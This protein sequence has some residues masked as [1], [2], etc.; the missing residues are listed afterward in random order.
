M[1]AS[2]ALPFQAPP[3]P[4]DPGTVALR[5]ESVLLHAFERRPCFVCDKTG[6][7]RHREPKLEMIIA[8]HI[9]IGAQL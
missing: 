8:R 1:S 5:T 2:P 9:G 4:I 3:Q 7:C 6:W